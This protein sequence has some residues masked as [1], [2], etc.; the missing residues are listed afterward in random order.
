MRFCQLTGVAHLLLGKDQVRE[1]LHAESHPG[2]R[3]SEPLIALRALAPAIYGSTSLV[4]LVLVFQSFAID[5]V[6][7]VNA[8]SLKF[9][10][11]SKVT[12]TGA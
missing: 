8:Y 7:R 10:D 3:M 4:V 9:I 6:K 1:R 2:G 11:R 12:R 5:I